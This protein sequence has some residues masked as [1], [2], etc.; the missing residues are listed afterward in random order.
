MFCL[1]CEILSL[2]SAYHQ[3]VVV[4][5][6]WHMIIWRVS[7]GSYD[8]YIYIY[9]YSLITF[10]RALVLLTWSSGESLMEAM[11][12]IY[13]AWSHSF[14]HLFCWHDHLE[15]VS[16]KLWYIYI[17]S[18]ITFIRALVLLTWSSGECL[19][20]AM[21]YIAWSHSFVHLFCWNVVLLLRKIGWRA[22]VFLNQ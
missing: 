22:T 6:G 4:R 5:R 8:I 2:L 18:L 10:I 3:L 17:Y 16:W 11:I 9:I 15:S 13:I 19:M 20:E 1:F 12:Y 7:H 21:I 14:V